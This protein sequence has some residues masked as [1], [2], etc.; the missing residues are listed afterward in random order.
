VAGLPPD[1]EG[2]IAQSTERFPALG[3]HLHLIAEIVNEVG[4][5]LPKDGIFLHHEDANRHGDL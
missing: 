2:L 4:K 5:H 3:D 1:I